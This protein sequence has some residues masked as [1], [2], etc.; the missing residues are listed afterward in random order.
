VKTSCY[1]CGNDEE[2]FGIVHYCCEEH[3]PGKL[4]REHAALRSALVAILKRQD[5]LDWQKTD[6]ETIAFAKEA[7]EAMEQVGKATEES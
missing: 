1:F 5:E 7:I 4:K 6:E 2:G 3:D